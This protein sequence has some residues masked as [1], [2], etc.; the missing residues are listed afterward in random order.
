MATTRRTKTAPKKPAAKKPAAKKPAAKKPAAKKPPARPFEL[1]GP[2]HWGYPFTLALKGARKKDAADFL[3]RFTTV[4]PA[5]ELSGYVVV[6]DDDLDAAAK[7][8]EK[9][10]P[11]IPYSCLA[12]RWGRDLPAAERLAR[13]DAALA[14]PDDQSRAHVEMLLA[15]WPDDQDPSAAEARA[16]AAMESWPRYFRSST[17]RTERAAQAGDLAPHRT[18]VRHYASTDLEGT[19]DK[20][21]YE[22]VEMTQFDSP[23]RLV[24]HVGRFEHLREVAFRGV[25]TG[26]E[27]EAIK[28]LPR[29]ERLAVWNFSGSAAPG[30]DVAR[31]REAPLGLGLRSLETYGVKLSAA[32]LAPF[33]K[34]PAT[35][36][37]LKLTNGR[38]SGAKAGKALAAIGARHPVRS[39]V[40]EYNELEG[41]GTAAAFAPG[42][43]AS[44][45]ALNLSANEVGDEGI[46]AIAK[47][48]SLGRLRWFTCR[49]NAAQG[50]ITAAGAAALADA[51]SLGALAW[52]GLMGHALG[53][54]GAARI[55]SSPK[56]R[57]LR[58]V[59]LS[60]TYASW[61]EVIDALRG[62]E[63]APLTHLDASSWDASG[64]VDWEAA[65]F[66]RG[67]RHL[68]VDGLP[69]DQ[70][71]PLLACG[72]LDALE[73]LVLGGAYAE[74]ERATAAL[75]K[76]RPLPR[77]RVISLKGW[78]LQTAG[79]RA[80]A[81]S[82]LFSTLSAVE[83]MASGYATADAAKEFLARG[84]RLV[85]IPEFDEYVFHDA[86]MH[87]FHVQLPR[88]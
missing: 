29:V 24:A 17:T 30:L 18:W 47:S 62:R 40:V 15:T 35:L 51:A 44:L 46:T 84:V 45:E 42:A 59:N 38:L 81:A 7:A 79:A 50:V 37:H 65:S 22:R 87:D 31:W 58:R 27:W 49:S 52:L 36:E 14:A 76:A 55:L 39:L 26:D 61:R 82:P 11:S 20:G 78:R 60:Y 3:S 53:S 56:L 23:A 80:L 2:I 34:G 73:S 67:V 63:T 74:H 16:L 85:T 32:E 75:R 1:C 77:L 54:D 12:A 28:G 70:Y 48:P 13:L 68:R 25:P 57:G 72:H 69:G 88:T 6:D 86:P 8:F 33:A 83:L 64:Q 5:S 41:P 4:A 66:L 10:R 21:M 9:N 19:L 43:W 71:G